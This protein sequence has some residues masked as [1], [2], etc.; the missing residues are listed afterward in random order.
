V[1]RLFWRWIW[2]ADLGFATQHPQ[3]PSAAVYGMHS[4]VI[5]DSFEVDL[6]VVWFT[7][8]GTW[9]NCGIRWWLLPNDIDKR[10]GITS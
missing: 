8:N 3:I 2:T 4:R 1:L 10:R 7:V 9:Q 5:H 6:A